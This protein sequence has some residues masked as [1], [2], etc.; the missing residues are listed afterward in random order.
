MILVSRLPLAALLIL[1]I[2]S[3]CASAPKQDTRISDEVYSWPEY[4]PQTTEGA[5]FQASRSGSLFEDVRARRVGDVVTVVLSE[6]TNAAQSASASTNKN[7]AIDIQNPTLFGRLFS[8][9]AG[10]LSSAPLTLENHLNSSKTFNGEGGSEQSNQLSGDITALVI[11]ELPNGYL[12]IRGE[13]L[14]S[15]NKGDEYIRLTGVIRPVDIQANNTIVS[16]MVANAEISYGGKGMIA[17]ASEMGWASR[18]F[19]SRWWPF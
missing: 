14:I 18:F 16:A 6:R 2:V 13:K 9:E 17:D 11:E 5:I 8:F 15:I 1:L 4:S 7:N 12:R 19:N 10:G 3:G